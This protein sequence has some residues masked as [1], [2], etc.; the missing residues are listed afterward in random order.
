MARSLDL[1]VV[2]TGFMGT[3][4]TT[5]GRL[6]AHELDWT[7][8]DTD[9]VI[10]AR[11]GPI[12]RIFAERGEDVF[13]SIE[14]EVAAEVARAEQQVIATGGRMLLDPTNAAA[15]SATGRVFCL[16]ADAD[17]LVRRLQSDIDGPVRPL[18]AGQEPAAAVSRLLDERAAGYGQFEQV[19]T[20]GRSPQDVAAVIIRL[21][22]A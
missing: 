11:H 5:V 22:E 21:L 9:D 17:E 6:V 10:V 1:N 12:E 19:H 8:V 13:R 2:L 20:A 4:K 14:Q 18:L 7:F 15:L 3:G 16:A